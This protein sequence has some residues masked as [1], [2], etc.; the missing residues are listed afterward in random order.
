MKRL[1]IIED[2]P[3][4][5]KQMVRTLQERLQG[6]IIETASRFSQARTKLVARDFD[7]IVSDLILPDSDGEHIRDLVEQGE[8]VIVLTG[9][10]DTRFKE[11]IG[12]LDIVDYLLKSESERFEYLSWLIERLEKN[13]D[14]KVLV[15]E[16]AE[17]MRKMYRRLL[18]NQNLTVLEASDGVEALERLQTDGADLIVSDYNMPRMDGLDLLR[19]VRRNHSMIDL[20][21]IAVSSDEGDDTVARFLKHGANDFLKKPFGK[22]ELLCRINNTLDTL[23]MMRKIRENA[24]RDP[25][26]GLYNRRYLYEIS[27]KLIA[28]AQRYE[29]PLSVVMFDVDHFK[30]VNDRYGHLM[31]DTVLGTVAKLMVASLRRSDVAIRFGGEEFLVLMPGTDGKRAF[32]AA[33]KLR[34]AVA[35]FHIPL[36][37]EGRL[38]VHLSAG[39]AQYE[40]GLDLDALIRRADEALYRAKANG[41]N[42][43]EM[44]DKE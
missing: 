22:E 28:S 15:V 13:R 33:E 35:S 18:R 7:L 36:G 12:S 2:D 44:Y 24:L 10:A 29:T 40:K 9:H 39:V 41:R 11:R 19:K 3:F 17:S 32:V 21:F 4:Y 6:W 8:K 5:R 27:D 20:P 16:D 31:G 14:K 37:D 43:V 42:R 38:T 25:L 1:L 34:R 23:D 30:Q 26:T